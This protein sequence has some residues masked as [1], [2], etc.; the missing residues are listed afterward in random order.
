MNFFDIIAEY[1]L[2]A[3]PFHKTILSSVTEETCQEYA[4]AIY[5]CDMQ[6]IY[7]IARIALGDELA[8]RYFVLGDGLTLDIN[9][10][11]IRAAKG[12]EIGIHVSNKFDFVNFIMTIYMMATSMVHHDP[13]NPTAG[14]WVKPVRAKDGKVL[15]SE[16]TVIIFEDVDGPYARHVKKINAVNKQAALMLG[17]SIKTL[18]L[19]NTMKRVAKASGMSEDT[20]NKK[21]GMAAGLADLSRETVFV[22][23]FLCNVVPAA[24][25]YV[26]PVE[27]IEHTDAESA[28][29]YELPRY[30][31]R[32]YA[33]YDSWLMCWLLKVASTTK[34]GKFISIIEEHNGD[35]LVAFESSQITI[36]EDGVYDDRNRRFQNVVFAPDFQGKQDYV[37]EELALVDSHGAFIMSVVNTLSVLA[38]SKQMGAN[39]PVG[40]WFRSMTDITP[41]DTESEAG[42]DNSGKRGD[43]NL[44]ATQA[45]NWNG[46]L[47]F[48]FTPKARTQ[49]V[50]G[51]KRYA[52]IKA[53]LTI[54]CLDKFN[55]VQVHKGNMTMM[56]ASWISIR[57]N[58]FSPETAKK[59]V[60]EIFQAAYG[61]AWQFEIVKTFSASY[62]KDNELTEE[63]T[64]DAAVVDLCVEEFVSHGHVA[65]STKV[66]KITK[67]IT[68][69][70]PSAAH[71]INGV[72]EAF[73]RIGSKAPMAHGHR[74]AIGHFPMLINAP[75]VVFNVGGKQ[76]AFKVA[77]NS[78][79]PVEKAADP[80]NWEFPF[81]GSISGNGV[82]YTGHTSLHVKDGNEYAGV[83]V[84]KNDIV[85]RVAYKVGESTHYKE[86]KAGH[87]GMLTSLSWVDLEFG[88]CK[89]TTVRVKV[90]SIQRNAKI[91]NTV[92]ALVSRPSMAMVD[93][94]GIGMIDNGLNTGIPEGLQYIIT[95]DS[96]KAKDLVQSYLD[97]AAETFVANGDLEVIKAANALVGYDDENVLRYHE[98][99]AAMGCYNPLLK[100]FYNQYG[101]AVWF[102]H[103]GAKDGLI[104]ALRTL[105]VNR[106]DSDNTK[107]LR[108]SYLDILKA[109]PEVRNHDFGAPVEDLIFITS[110]VMK[111]GE[112]SKYDEIFVFGVNED[113]EVDGV[114][115]M[116]EVL[117]QRTYGFIGNEKHGHVYINTRVELCS[118]DDSVTNTR[119]MAATA[120][121]VELGLG[122]V[123]GD[124]SLAK[125]LMSGNEDRIR[126][127]QL[128]KAMAAGHPIAVN[129]ELLP[130][131]SL[132]DK[133][134]VNAYIL[135]LAK[136]CATKPGEE[137]FIDEFSELAKEIVVTYNGAK[138]YLP[139]VCRM[140]RSADDRQTLKGQ[141]S[142]LIVK[143]LQGMKPA[144]LNNRVSVIKSTLKTLAESDKPTKKIFQ[145]REGWQDK[146]MACF[147][148]P[149]D[150]YICIRGSKVHEAAVKSAI[151]EGIITGWHEAEKLEGMKMLTSRSP[152]PFPACLKFYTVP[153]D[154]PL[155]KLG[156][157]SQGIV[158]GLV[159]NV[160]GGDHDGDGY[161][162]VFIGD[163]DYPLL[164]KEMVLN[165]LEAR[166]GNVPLTADDDQ[167]IADHYTPKTWKNWKN[168]ESPQMVGAAN[169]RL[170]DA[171]SGDSVITPN[172]DGELRIFTGFGKESDEQAL[173]CSTTLQQQLVGSM[174]RLAVSG[175]LAMNISHSCKGIIKLLD[176]KY[177]EELSTFF[178]S[179]KAAEA[180]YELYEGGTL[181]GLS[182]DA[183]AGV[184]M[185]DTVQKQGVYQEV[186]REGKIDGSRLGHFL[187]AASINADYSVAYIQAAAD[188]ET[189]KNHFGTSN[190]YTASGEGNDVRFRKGDDVVSY[191]LTGYDMVKRLAYVAYLLCGG[192]FKPSITKDGKLNGHAVLAA[193]LYN[194][195]VALWDELAESS[196]AVHLLRQWFDDCLHL[197]CPKIIKYTCHLELDGKPVANI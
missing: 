76:P 146:T 74:T 197:E 56:D 50:S 81:G 48:S 130:E 19:S 156:N 34:N 88:G 20:L 188:I 152:L 169:L 85:C 159:C 53:R 144:E 151:N 39:V 6:A 25:N 168:L 45:Y 37:C 7:D 192:R 73:S 12:N 118:V 176:E 183:F 162:H 154:H 16:D 55:L 13:E 104:S 69:G 66:S 174:H 114:G 58:H 103:L 70:M 42:A 161:T 71:A 102:K 108:R 29:T 59:L 92:K 137:G 166:T 120:R 49:K 79:T 54:P 106:G 80:F 32:A 98:I 35:I 116:P 178:H 2:K 94:T 61:D 163:S 145:G 158:N 127:F 194:I 173:K 184:S 123:P 117:W 131:V 190:Y 4:N 109:C 47:P 30:F 121:S 150:E 31:E 26:L 43:F 100:K 36:K 133:G 185:L 67:R 111:N 175:E 138:L 189:I 125:A 23:D 195:P 1:D 193:Q 132:F 40:T 5:A 134:K 63:S 51:I 99:L 46:L 180:F 27:A 126:S 68:L 82:D 171:V 196:V 57:F 164:T 177:G 10:E 187:A 52:G 72:L 155:A 75:G 18:K 143:A 141:V 140:Q 24:G 128:I 97:V 148:A 105:Y 157:G 153:E 119:I 147:G 112:I 83:F 8:D 95:G 60:K 89:V 91:R 110:N 135:T 172:K 9:G 186:F 44:V 11:R 96:D 160:S 87:T 136:A 139:Q 90:T 170:F 78:T 14:N 21:I 38:H 142:D 22:A 101:K 115:A 28:F 122:G 124:A 41:M 129:E 181:G 65:L 179:E 149:V 191:K 77:K 167:Y 107:W 64:I 165:V 113:F 33:A 17:A 84:H 93:G 62:L 15:T 182:W 86:V 3:N